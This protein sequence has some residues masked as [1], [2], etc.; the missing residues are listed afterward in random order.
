M[1]IND[2]F[3]GGLKTAFNWFFWWV[4]LPIAVVVCVMREFPE[5]EERF[6]NL[7]RGRKKKFGEEGQ[8]DE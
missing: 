5:V 3:D 4:F 1:A 6:D 7:L 2:Y 8:S